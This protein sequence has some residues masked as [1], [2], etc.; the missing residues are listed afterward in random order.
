MREAD[1]KGV[2]AKSTILP[3]SLA[4]AVVVAA[5]ERQ[6]VE[7]APAEPFVGSLT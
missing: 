2:E 6:Q 1:E 3:S 4:F 5:V 7:K